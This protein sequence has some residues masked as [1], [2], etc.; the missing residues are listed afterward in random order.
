MLEC[1]PDAE[2]YTWEKLDP[3]SAD[4]RKVVE[5]YWCADTIRG[6]ECLDSK[7]FK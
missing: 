2:Y 4:A 3:A 7:V 5:D 1:N 6:E